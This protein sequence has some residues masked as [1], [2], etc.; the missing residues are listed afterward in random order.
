VPHEPLAW[1]P[2][3][4][5]QTDALRRRR[6]KE[7]MSLIAN[8]FLARAVVALVTSALVAGACA[9]G[10]GGGPSTEETPVAGGRLIVGSFTDIQR[11]NPAT[12]NDSSSTNVS[13]KIYDALLTADHKTGELK[14]WL[15]T[16]E[17]SSDN[18][19]YSWK[20]DPNANWSDGKPITG[21]DFLARVKMQAR[22]KVTPNRSVFNDVEGYQ[23]YS[24]GQATSISGIRVDSSN[25]KNFTVKFTRV[26]CNI[27]T[28]FGSAPMPEHIFGK[29]TVDNDVNQNVDNAPENNAP[30]VSSGPFKFKEW[31]RGD[32]VIL[33]KNENYFKGAPYVDEYVYKVV[34]DTTVQAA[35]LRTGELTVARIQPA[36]VATLAN[37]ENVRL[38]KWADN[39]YVYIGWRV[40]NPNVSFLQDKRVRQALMYGLNMDQVVQSVL[41]GEGTKMVSHHPPVAWAAAPA[42]QLNQ[43]AFD[44]TR[45][46]N[47]LKEA[48]YTKSGDFYAKDGKRLSITIVTN[49][50]NKTRET[51]LQVATE[52][53]K[54][55]G[56]EIKPKLEAFES[57]VPKLTGGSPE[58][59]G[60]IIG[61]QLATD[62]DPFTIW[63]SSN[64]ATPTKA[65]NNFVGYSNPQVDRLIEQGR[66]GPDCSQAARQK[67]YQE[68][69]K[70]LNDDVPY[71]FGFAQ[72]RILAADARIRGIDV[73][74]FSPEGDWNI[75]KWWIKQ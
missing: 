69:N 7:G 65:G 11:L 33:T 19:T 31:R 23:A 25:P 46:E 56:V 47:L 52:Q 51:F 24:T 74:S 5:T 14:P 75:H 16:W 38:H 2:G 15:G 35:Q 10:P 37:A 13:S 12:S 45:A 66:N 72:N 26:F 68:M 57:L 73:G 9:G 1:G 50:G 49:Q 54:Q 59:E 27:S 22:S 55:M 39:G 36:D 48:G 30:P 21:N 4:Q 28:L 18:L 20:I 63:H 17:V 67:V 8:R 53:Y 32:Q 62:P 71:N 70:I 41:F 29:Y 34:A 60:I 42:A 3:T 61:W 44:R 64:V 43:Y 58:I 40:N 6:E